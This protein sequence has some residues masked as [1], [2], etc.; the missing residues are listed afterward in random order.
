MKR[1]TPNS[2][3]LW[4]EAGAS[5]RGHRPASRGRRAGRGARGQLPLSRPAPAADA[6]LRG[7]GRPLP[8]PGLAHSSGPPA[9]S[10]ASPRG[11]R[12]RAPSRGFVHVTEGVDSGKLGC[13][14]P[15]EASTAHQGE[16]P[17]PWQGL[18]PLSAGRLQPRAHAPPP[19]CCC[20]FCPRLAV[21]SVP[22]A[23]TLAAMVGSFLPRLSATPPRPAMPPLAPPCSKALSFPFSPY[24]IFCFVLYLPPPEY[25]LYEGRDPPAPPFLTGQ[26]H[27][28]PHQW[29]VPFG[30]FV[31]SSDL[32]LRSSH[33]VQAEAEDNTHGAPC[34]KLASGVVRGDAGRSWSRCVRADG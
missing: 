3:S 13:R 4:C 5:A 19:P 22:S 34:S 23:R 8:L 10:H 15:L 18:R 9:W 25:I 32:S 26:S 11:R 1:E 12:P 14:G 27:V 24:F 16:L 2:G 17:V 6:S 31:P 29:P 33:P 28:I 30:S 7:L 21:P 20:F